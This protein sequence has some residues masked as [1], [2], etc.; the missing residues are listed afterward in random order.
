V[1]DRLFGHGKVLDL[2]PDTG[3]PQVGQVA[4]G[5]AEGQ[6][7]V[8]FAQN[9]MNDN[10]TQLDAEQT[11]NQSSSDREIPVENK[12]EKSSWYGKLK[13]KIK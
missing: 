1:Y 4:A 10:T 6:D 5:A 2:F 9:V 8:S 11:N 12:K 3:K 7:S 13:K